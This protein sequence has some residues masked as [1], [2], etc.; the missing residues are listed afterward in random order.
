M[1]SRAVLDSDDKARFDLGTYIY[2]DREYRLGYSWPV[3]YA[4]CGPDEG[5]IFSALAEDAMVHAN[6]TDRPG[7]RPPLG[8]AYARAVAQGYIR[9]ESNDKACGR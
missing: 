2:E 4:Q 7:G 5:E 9:Q 1:R 6:L 3:L 8:E